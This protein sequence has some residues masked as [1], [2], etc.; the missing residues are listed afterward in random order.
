[1]NLKKNLQLLLKERGWTLARLARE[2]KV[3]K[4]TIGDW[5]GSQTAIN[6]TQL[7]KVADALRVPVWRLAY[8]LDEPDPHEKYP[9]EL[10]QE[11]F[12]G[13][14]MVTIA[15]VLPGKAKK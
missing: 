8:S 1:M 9:E 10:I 15:R 11:I 5:T 6:L 2:S 12:S 3:P 4:S 14:L 7:R 13:K